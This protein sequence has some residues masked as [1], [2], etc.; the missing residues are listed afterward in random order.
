MLEI[1]LSK[2]EKSFGFNKVLDK[3]NMD[4][5]TSERVALIGPNGCG[6]STVLKII[7]N[8]ETIDSGSISIRKNAT[9]GYLSQIPDLRKDNYTVREV[10][11]E[12]FNDLIILSDHLKELESK[13]STC[14]GKDLD[15]AI[16]SYTSL[17]EKYMNM[18]G[19]E[20]DSTISKVCAVFKITELMMEQSYNS[21]SGGEKTIVNLAS[22]V[23]SKPSILLLD[24]PTNHLD[25]DALEWLENYLINYHGTVLIVSHDRYF[26][27]KVINKIVLIEKGSEVVFYGNYS[28]YLKENEKRIMDEFKNYK[29]QE[30]QI[31][32][33]K[34]A[35][36]R[37][38]EWGR[39]AA[40][41]GGMFFRR[42]HNIQRRLDRM[43]I[44]EKPL[45]KKEI[46]IAF[47][48]DKRSANNVLNIKDLDLSIEKKELYNNVNLKINFKDKVCIMGKNG[49]GK[50]TLIK[51]IL[52]NNNEHIIM[53]SN[54]HIGYIPQ[55][56]HFKNDKETVIEYARHN[57]HEDENKLRSG[58]VRYLFFGDD[59]YK[60]IR[61]LS[62]GEK[63]RL[64]LFDLINSDCNFLI[65]DEPTN[66]ID[67]ETKELLENSLKKYLGTILFISHD[68]YFINELATKIFYIDNLKIKEYDGNYN[69]FINHK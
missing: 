26:M 25:I 32:A 15:K 52:N 21:L 69:Y 41:E 11:L 63:V 42:A 16:L 20:I 9:I 27:D 22:L 28:N 67:I 51:E 60:E 53:G 19:Y 43:E 40:P 35:I 12:S 56:I 66:H 54:V 45:E 46:P 24:E 65:L 2:I 30:K 3:F 29:T 17:Q 47:K 55:E 5:K 64:L 57:F 18:G 4:I 61:V 34:K 50:T 6:K 38:E 14:K 58:L 8:L 62:G 33:M 39:Q 10:L 49:T 36:K 13:M 44:L 31:D 7:N 1:S 48:F 23:I 37:L 59:I 68:R